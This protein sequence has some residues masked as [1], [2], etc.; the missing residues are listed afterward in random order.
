MEDDKDNEVV[1][2]WR[3]TDDF[4]YQ[5]FLVYRRDVPWIESGRL[6]VWDSAPTWPHTNR[7]GA[8]YYSGKRWIVWVKDILVAQETEYADVNDP[9]KF[10]VESLVA[11]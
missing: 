8:L 11:V 5:C 9:P 1:K 3:K 10:M 4:N 2:W 6:H 7:L